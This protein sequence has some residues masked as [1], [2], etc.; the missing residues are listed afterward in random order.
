MPRPDDLYLDDILLAA[1]HIDQFISGVTKDDFMASELIRSAVL[2]KLMV[3]GEAAA[4]ISADLK[5]AHPQVP[6]RNIAGFRNHAIHAYFSV[7]WEVVW[8]TATLESPKLA[9]QVEQVRS[10]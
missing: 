10:S 9:A 2:Q 8:V 7:N 3:I 4:R 1:S 6:W 5:A